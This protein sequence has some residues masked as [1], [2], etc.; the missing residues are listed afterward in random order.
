MSDLQRE[1][2]KLTRSNRHFVPGQNILGLPGLKL[3]S[4]T[5]DTSF[6][7]SSQYNEKGNSLN[8]S[9]PFLVGEIPIGFQLEPS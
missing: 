1:K 6:V 8:I 9:L 3:Q 5:N 7:S 4:G 2:I